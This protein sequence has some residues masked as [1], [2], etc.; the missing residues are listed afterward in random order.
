ME[1]IE[2]RDK[3][4]EQYKLVQNK[5]LENREYK[6]EADEDNRSPFERDYARILYSGA[7]RRLQGKMQIFGIEPSDF[8]RNRLTHSLEVAVLTNSIVNTINKNFFEKE[9]D[10][11]YKDDRYVLQAAALAHDIGH[12]A[13][14]H[15]GERVLDELSKKFNKR[16]EGN[17]QNYRVLRNLEN[18]YPYCSGLNLT[19]RTLLSINK[20]LVKENESNEKFM[21]EDDFNFLNDIREK[22]NLSNKR[23]LDVQIIDI[24]DEIAYAVHDLEDALSLR[25]FNME[26]FIFLMEQKDK[27]AGSKLKSIV[28]KVANTKMANST[29]K[30]IQGYSQIFRRTLVSELTGIFVKDIT[31]KK[32]NQEFAKEHGV[33]E[34][35]YELSLN[36]YKEL[37]HQMKKITFDCSQRN[38]DIALYEK[39]GAV[40]IKSLYDLYSDNN[41]NKDGILLPMVYR[42]NDKYTLNQGSIDYIAGMMDTFAIEEYEKLYNKKFNE[43]SIY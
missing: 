19:Y 31:I 17:A 6:I 28:E 2:I 34:D 21:Y 38:T 32:N 37:C 23:T 25:H 16:F 30:T 26:E 20:Y 43:I 9:E 10:F 18:R 29:H 12:P 7:F 35:D 41:K 11:I 4:K 36:E 5:E 1:K 39:K 40:I 22:Y 13:F 27:N 24:A 33:K 8:I 14:G 15:S 42:P 3:I